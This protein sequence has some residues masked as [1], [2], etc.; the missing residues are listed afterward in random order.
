MAKCHNF[1]FYLLQMLL[2]LAVLHFHTTPWLSKSWN[3]NNVFFR[4]ASEIGS[5]SRPT[6]PIP[7]LNAK[8]TLT[9]ST[10]G[11]FNTGSSAS[12]AGIVPNMLLFDLGVMLLELAYNAPFQS[13]RQ[14]E[15]LL[16][17]SETTASDFV[18]AISLADEVGISLGAGFAAIVKKCLRC[19]FGY[20]NNLGHPALQARLYEDVVCKLERLEDGFRK[21]QLND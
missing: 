3:S 7:H 14:C 8:V 12:L 6:D 18:A 16:V 10:A 4:G 13:L 20:E 11:S 17:S 19:D 2:K 15:T 9:E 21:F 1:N 5:E